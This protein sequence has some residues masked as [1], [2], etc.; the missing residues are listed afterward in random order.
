M[1]LLLVGA[2]IGAAVCFYVVRERSAAD[3]GDVE[4]E[5]GSEPAP[6]DEAY[7][8][9]K[10][11]EWNLTPDEVKKDLGAAGKVVRE[12]SRALGHKVA[13]AT[14]DVA[15]IGKIKAKYAIDDRL[16]AL[17]ISVGCKQGHVTLS[18][19]V[20][21]PELVGRAVALALDTEDVVEVSSTLKVAEAN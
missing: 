11:R 1:L 5:A 10:L 7:I 19:T 18:G 9:R 17:K 3:A 15:I 21:A 8:S 4:V 6:R 16:Q 20:A 13:D 14:S 2:A 12:K